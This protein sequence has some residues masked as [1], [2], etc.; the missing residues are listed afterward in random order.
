MTRDELVSHNINLNEVRAIRQA[1]ETPERHFEVGD[2]V[3][4]RMTK[5]SANKIYRKAKETGIR[6]SYVGVHYTPEV[7]Q[8][9]TAK[10]HNKL[11]SQNGIH[12]SYKP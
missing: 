9:A 12:I 10:H 4:I 3:R 2:L 6:W 8:V 7:F 1:S 5:L 11:T